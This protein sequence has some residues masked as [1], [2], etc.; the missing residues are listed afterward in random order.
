MQDK[1]HFVSRMFGRI[2][3]RYDLGNRVLSLGQDLRWRRSA[4]AL[5]KPLAHD[6]I[7][8]V[9]AGTGDLALSLAGSAQQVVALDFSQPML[10]IGRRK[11]A[12][13]DHLRG[14]VTLVLSDALALPFQDSSFDCVTS[15]F[16]VRNLA[17]T[18]DGFKESCRILKPGGRM[19]CLEFTRPPSRLVNL[20]YQPYL[21]H[22]LPFLG[23][24][25][26]GDRSAYTYLADS[27]NS[28]PSAR[29]LAEL[30][31]Q[32]G[33]ERVEYRLLNL[34]TVAAHLSHKAR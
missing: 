3:H 33:F 9:G 29:E 13:Q 2:A 12:P 20:L 17:R 5:L 32:A 14:R 11:A 21:K 7:L 27:I 6:I 19:L 16:T 26:T 10:E 18:E 23:A 31:R 28:F 34:G 1:A 22:V 25:I 30:I 24:Q 8:D 15:A 4:M